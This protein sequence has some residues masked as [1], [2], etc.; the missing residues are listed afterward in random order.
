MLPAAFSGTEYCSQ[1]AREKGRMVNLHAMASK[2]PQLTLLDRG[3][4]RGNFGVV[5]PDRSE[6]FTIRAEGGML[7]SRH[8]L[9]QNESPIWRLSVRSILRRRHELQFMSGETWSLQTP[10]FSVFFGGTAQDESRLLGRVGRSTEEWFFLVE[11]GKETM[12]LLAAIA[13]L[14]CQWYFRS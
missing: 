14:H 5:G 9:F 7:R 4:K 11:P 10:F 6:L 8:S 3:Y 1:I 13:F 12:E 2:D